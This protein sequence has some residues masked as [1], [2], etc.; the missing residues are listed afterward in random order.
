MFCCWLTGWALNT[1]RLW[2][3]CSQSWRRRRPYTWRWV[4]A[5]TSRWR[6]LGG[7][8]LKVT[9]QISPG[10]WWWLRPRRHLLIAKCCDVK[11]SKFRYILPLMQDSDILIS[12]LGLISWTRLPLTLNFW[13]ALSGL[14]VWHRAQN[15]KQ[16]V[17]STRDFFFV[18]YIDLCYPPAIFSCTVPILLDIWLIFN[19]FENVT[20][21]SD[22]LSDILMV[23]KEVGWQLVQYLNG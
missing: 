4:K 2:T 6:S 10:L 9:R 22:H 18:F 7:S 12:V 16:F 15:A 19:S 11:P 23:E 21:L 14:K 1:S 13:E 8:R 17:K 3:F 20:T 5:P